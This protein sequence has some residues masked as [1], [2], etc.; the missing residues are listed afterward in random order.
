M[1]HFAGYSLALRV[2]KIAG[3]I[4]EFDL[5][6]KRGLDE[7]GN[8][9]LLVGLSRVSIDVEPAWKAWVAAQTAQDVRDISRDV[10]KMLILHPSAEP[11]DWREKAFG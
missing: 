6:K 11:M 5:T 10:T 1:R 2:P 8:E 3:P 9:F 7:S 4:V